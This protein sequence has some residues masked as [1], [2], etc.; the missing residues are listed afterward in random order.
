[1]NRAITKSIKENETNKT[2]DFYKIEKDDEKEERLKNLHTLLDQKQRNVIKGVIKNETVVPAYTK[3]NKGMNEIFREKLK[4][5]VDKMVRPVYENQSTK[6]SRYTCS[7]LNKSFSNSKN[8][9]IFKNMIRMERPKSANSYN[10][11]MNKSKSSSNLTR[12]ELM[13]TLANNRLCSKFTPEYIYTIRN[14]IDRSD[15]STTI[16][17]TDSIY[18]QPAL[19]SN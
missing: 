6:T 14:K 3:E 10:N 16:L 19:N 12:S 5:T 1:M 17:L 2:T 7:N 9:K 13:S 8:N 18:E 4:C 11:R 15:G